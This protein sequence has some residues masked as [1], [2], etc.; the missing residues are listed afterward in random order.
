MIRQRRPAV[1]HRSHALSVQAKARFAEADF[2]GA[3]LFAEAVLADDPEHE[4][5]MIYAKSCREGLSEMYVGQYGSWTSVARVSVSID[6]LRKMETSATDWFVIAC[7]DGSS[8]L[9][10][11]VRALGMPQHKA[12]RILTDLLHRGILRRGA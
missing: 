9:A 4:T 7:V 5:A 1:L 8:T 11:I 6:M 12:L 2:S 10:E 3:L